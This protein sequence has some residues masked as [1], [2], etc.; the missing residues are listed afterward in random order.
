MVQH[1]GREHAKMVAFGRQHGFTVGVSAVSPSLATSW[2]VFVLTGRALPS[3]VGT[4]SDCSV[5]LKIEPSR[6]GRNQLYREARTAGFAEPVVLL[7]TRFSESERRDARMLA[8]GDRADLPVRN[9]DNELTLC[10]IGD[11][12]TEDAWEYVGEVASGLLATTRISARRSASTRMPATAAVR[13]S[14]S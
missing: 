11:W 8:R 9:S 7:G 10:P 3:Y 6:I 2:Q 5:S 1:A 13:S 12:S 4:N 14:R